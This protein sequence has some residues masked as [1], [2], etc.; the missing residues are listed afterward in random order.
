MPW[1]E[2]TRLIVKKKKESEAFLG[3]RRCLK[4]MAVEAL[5]CA[6]P[7]VLPFLLLDFKGLLLCA[8]FFLCPTWPCIARKIYLAGM[9]YCLWCDECSR[10]R[11]ERKWQTDAWN[12][13][14]V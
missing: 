7:S 3:S 4:K 14:S 9:A 5:P 12:W 13:L 6:W 1:R 10:C 8:F 2:K 11:L